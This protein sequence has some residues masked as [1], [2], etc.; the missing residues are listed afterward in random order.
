M[1][2]TLYE[3]REMKTLKE[4]KFTLSKFCYNTIVLMN[5][6]EYMLRSE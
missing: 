6:P 3:Y 1:S 4:G 2:V 5:F